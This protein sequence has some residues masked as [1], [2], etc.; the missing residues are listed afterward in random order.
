MPLQER[1]QGLD[2]S[3]LSS[4]AEAASNSTQAVSNIVA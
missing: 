4:Y 1:M 2:G 3:G